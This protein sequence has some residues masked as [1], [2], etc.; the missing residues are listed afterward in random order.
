MP[1]TELRGEN[2]PA[3]ITQNHTLLKHCQ[4]QKTSIQL[5]G[6]SDF[7]QKKAEQFVK[8]V[9]ALTV[10]WANTEKSGK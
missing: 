1:K 9:R 7:N 3:S 10:H 6:C 2:I 8:L 5:S 4:K